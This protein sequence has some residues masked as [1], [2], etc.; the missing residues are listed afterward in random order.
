MTIRELRAIRDGQDKL[1][2]IRNGPRRIYKTPEYRRRA[3]KKHYEKDKV[4][5][6]R[7]IRQ[8]QRAQPHD[9]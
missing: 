3:S 2:W 4:W 6:L 7:R 8:Y 9:W 1:D 5:I